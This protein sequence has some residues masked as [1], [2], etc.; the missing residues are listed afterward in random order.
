LKVG[1]EK[2]QTEIFFEIDWLIG[3]TCYRSGVFLASKN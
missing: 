3:T 1:G 2:K